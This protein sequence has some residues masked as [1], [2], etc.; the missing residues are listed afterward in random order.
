[1][2]M[3]F[4]NCIDGSNRIYTTYGGNRSYLGIDAG[5]KEEASAFFA[6][7]NYTGQLN[8]LNIVAPTC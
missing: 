5:Q 6:G 8:K 3:Y 7:A 1:M 4:Q 2:Q